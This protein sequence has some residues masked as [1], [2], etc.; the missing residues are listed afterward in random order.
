MR[1]SVSLSGR[2]IVGVTA[3]NRTGGKKVRRINRKAGR[4]RRFVEN[5]L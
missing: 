5:I 2:R 1:E 3:F 4:I